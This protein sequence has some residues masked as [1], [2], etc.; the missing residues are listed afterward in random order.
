MK[1]YHVSMSTGGYQF[2]AYGLTEGE[3]L[4]MLY[5]E[6]QV[7]TASCGEGTAPKGQSIHGGTLQDYYGVRVIE[8]TEFPHCEVL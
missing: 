3:A 4:D 1:V 7:L 8:V 2:D 6:Y 5:K